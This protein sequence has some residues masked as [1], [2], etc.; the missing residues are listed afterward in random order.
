MNERLFARMLAPL[1]R[2]LANM[3]MRGMVSGVNDSGKVQTLQV[4]GLDGSK[5]DFIEHVEHYGLSVHPKRGAEH[6]SLFLQGSAS[7]GV[8]LVVADRRYRQ[9]GMEEGE[10]ALHDDQG[11]KVYLT[12]N[13]IVIDGGGKEINITNTPHVI[14]DTPK[15]TFAHDVEILGKLDVTQNITGLANVT[16]LALFSI[17]NI[18]AFSASAT[19]ISMSAMKTTYNGHTHTDPQGGSVGTPS[20]T[21]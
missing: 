12:R 10:V 14:A 2:A 9:K 1:E 11:Q 5:K 20:A 3:V 8:T 7:H 4:G 21:M 15:F 19:P 18:T 6:V 17:G 16:G 13:G